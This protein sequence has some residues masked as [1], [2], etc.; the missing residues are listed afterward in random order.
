MNI[1]LD[2]SVIVKW[3]L[4]D[5]RDAYSD[6]LKED[7][8]QG[9]ISLYAPVLL[10]YEMQSILNSALKRNRI[11][12]AEALQDIE[13]FFDLGIKFTY[14][15]L[16][17]AQILKLSIEKKISVYDAAYV[18]LSKDKEIPLYTADK[19]LIKAVKNKLVLDYMDYELD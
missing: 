1:I 15:E 5:E 9:K 12:K 6:R 19:K 8:T 2:A 3:F 16:F 11:K 18:I 14:P 13:D 10:A 4:E 7:F 17:E